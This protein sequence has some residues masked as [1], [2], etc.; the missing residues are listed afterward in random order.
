MKD[1]TGNSEQMDMKTVLS[2]LEQ[3]SET[4]E[5][6]TSIVSRLESYVQ[7]HL[8]ESEEPRQA[9]FRFSL[10]DEIH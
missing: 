2:T 1:K 10:S 3:V 9:G 7:N 8:E 4:L 5:V 6:L